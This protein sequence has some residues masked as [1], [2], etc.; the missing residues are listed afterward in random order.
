M[1]GGKHISQI[2]FFF[3]CPCFF[4]IELLTKSI[5]QLTKLH[6]IK[7]FVTYTVPLSGKGGGA[8]ETDFKHSATLKTLQ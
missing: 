5:C 3:P 8:S 6:Q 1:T 2:L 7:F 4:L